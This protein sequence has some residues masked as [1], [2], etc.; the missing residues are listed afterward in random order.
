[1]TCEQGDRV[2]VIFVEK[3]EAMIIN[4]METL[5][6]RIQ[7]G[8]W[9]RLWDASQFTNLSGDCF[10]WTW[11]LVWGPCCAMEMWGP[12]IQTQKEDIGRDKYQG[13]LLSESRINATGDGSRILAPVGNGKHAILLPRSLLE[14][15][16]HYNNFKT[17]ALTAIILP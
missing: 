13:V 4:L 2:D 6:W 5:Y 12:G 17:F 16:R 15:V 9:Y 10:N 8:C 14:V 3:F 1:M 7:C 11:G